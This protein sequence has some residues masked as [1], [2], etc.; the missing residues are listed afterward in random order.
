MDDAALFKRMSFIQMS[1]GWSPYCLSDAA[2]AAEKL[3]AVGLAAETLENSQVRLRWNAPVDDVEFEVVRLNLDSAATG[4]GLVVRVP[5][6][7]GVPGFG[8]VPGREQT[9]VDSEVEPLSRYRYEIRPPTAS[10]SATWEHVDVNVV[11]KEVVIEGR[12]TVSEVDLKSPVHRLLLKAGAVLIT[13]GSDLDL[14][15]VELIVEGATIMTFPE[16]F[17]TVPGR[18]GRNGGRIQIV[19]KRAIGTDL[20]VIA[21]GEDG[22]DGP[23]LQWNTYPCKLPAGMS[24]A[25]F[26]PRSLSR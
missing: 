19:T 6:R 25:S 2:A 14:K 23:K 21:R 5:W 1:Y 12:R 26:T 7:S 18:S 11:G 15:L 10:A 9:F 17:G 24:A 13:E 8:P 4:A 20:I 16:H 3:P 22:G